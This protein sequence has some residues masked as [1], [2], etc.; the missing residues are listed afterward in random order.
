L[1]VLVLGA[2]IAGLSVAYEL[3]QRGVRVTVV[4]P[5][6]PG[7]VATSRSAGIVSLQL[8]GR[9]ASWALES[10]NLYERLGTARRVP[11]I[12]A[13]PRGCVEEVLSW[14]SSAGVEAG[15]LSPGEAGSILGVPVDPPGGWALAYTMDALVDVEAAAR[16]LLEELGRLNARLEAREAPGPYEALGDYDAVVVAA[17]AWT[18]GILGVPPGEIAGSTIYNCE[19]SS[20]H[21][22][23]I[24]KAILYVEHGDEA[25]YAAPEA[26]GRAIVGDG[27][28]EPLRDPGEAYPRP[29]TAYEVLEELARVSPAFEEAYPEASWAAPCLVTGDGLPAVGEWVEG[30]YILAGLDGYGLMAAPALASMLADHVTQGAPLPPRLDPHRRLKPWT[31][32]GAPPEPWRGC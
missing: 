14:A 10:L 20:V 1:K 24:L 26:L 28:N 15:P 2:G 16:G 8:P 12:L 13:A 30:I 25:A 17:G 11:G 9:L 4:D 19:A 31:G 23:G 6:G 32:E 18:P 29:A 7:G 5:E 22:P 3:S 21:V 27:P